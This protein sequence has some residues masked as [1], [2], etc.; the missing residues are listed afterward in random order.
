MEELFS[1]WEPKTPLVWIAALRILMGLVF[2]TT[3]F[4]NLGH[5]FYTPDGLLGFFTNIYPQADNPLTW[6]AAFV[7]NVILPV[8]SVFAPFQMVTE[9]LMGLCLLIGAFT[10]FFSLAGIFFLLNTF[11]ATLGHDWIWSYWIPIGILAVT[12]FSKAGRAWGVDAY[13][14]RRFGKKLWW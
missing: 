2:L 13:L 11:L 1:K 5:G 9:F 14:V 10:P 8:R 6:Y 7:N 3:W 12:F 4:I